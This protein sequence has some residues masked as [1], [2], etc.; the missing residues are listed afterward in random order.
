MSSGVID[1]LPSTDLPRS[2]V[3]AS[4][5]LLSVGSFIVVQNLL[6]VSGALK[7]SAL[8]L[9]VN[10]ALAMTSV[11]LELAFL[12]LI[13]AEKVQTESDEIK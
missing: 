11:V 13:S 6:G 2:T 3:L 4:F 7:N 1:Q 9:G 10:G 8:L 12:F 5:T